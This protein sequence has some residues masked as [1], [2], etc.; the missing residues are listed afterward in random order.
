[1]MHF[2]EE[3]ENLMSPKVF[4][5]EQMFHSDTQLAAANDLINNNIGYSKLYT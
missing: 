1:V 3:E 5:F 4:V 2:E